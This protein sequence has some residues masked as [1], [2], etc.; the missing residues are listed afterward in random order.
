[1]TLIYVSHDIKVLSKICERIIVLKD[2]NIVEE[3]DTIQ[4][5]KEPK[6]DY[7]KLLIKAATAD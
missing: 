6:N 5:L 4:I 2:G 3:N 1:M 7:T